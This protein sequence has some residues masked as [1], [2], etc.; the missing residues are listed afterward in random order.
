VVDIQVR[1]RSAKEEARKYV[2]IYVS[3]RYNYQACISV[4]QVENG[5]KA[6]K[7][8]YLGSFDTAELA[9]IAY[10][11]EAKKYPGRRLN[12]PEPA[13]EAPAESHTATYIQTGAQKRA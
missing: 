3:G 5:K 11:A 13:N 6:K 10:D 9:A 8:Q 12:F 4:T 2:G 1:L 7:L